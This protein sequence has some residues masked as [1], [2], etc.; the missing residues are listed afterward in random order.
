M[1]TI[2]Q[3]TGGGGDQL[4]IFLLLGFVISLTYIGILLTFFIKYGKNEPISRLTW[5]IFIA[6]IVM[7]SFWWGG[8][9]L[10]FPSIIGFIMWLVKSYRKRASQ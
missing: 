3:A 8:G 7:Q 10:L 4:T 2:D 6:V 9:Y 1:W 5:R